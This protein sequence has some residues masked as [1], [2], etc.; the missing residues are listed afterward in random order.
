[1]GFLGCLLEIEAV[2]EKGEPEQQDV[3]LFVCS[4]SLVLTVYRIRAA[5]RAVRAEEPPGIRCEGLWKLCCE[6]ETHTNEAGGAE[7]EALE[8][9]RQ[10]AAGSAISSAVPGSFFRF[11]STDNMNF[12]VLC[13][14]T[15]LDPRV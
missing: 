8:G 5:T 10:S 9:D 7:G 2:A 12:R 6:L 15:F 14:R 11:R 1:M 13:G 4:L 3:V